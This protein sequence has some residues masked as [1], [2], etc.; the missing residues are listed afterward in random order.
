MKIRHNVHAHAHA[1][2]QAL[3]EFALAATLIFMLLSATVDLGLIFLGRQALRTAAQEGATYGSRSLQTVLNSNQ[4]IVAVQLNE[5]EIRNRVRLSAG[6]QGGPTFVNMLDLNSNRMP[7]DNEGAAMLQEYI[8]IT[9]LRDADG[10]R[11]V[12]DDPVVTCNN[13]DM[14]QRP[15]QCYVRVTVRYDYRPVFPLA[16]AFGATVTIR[17]SF[18]V[19]VMSPYRQVNPAP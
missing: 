12:P 13:N 16:P 18:T 14:L 19:Q 3:V 15:D 9:N 5:N 10:D 4:R 17:E 11:R 1:H 8:Q 2:A 7:D 6:Q